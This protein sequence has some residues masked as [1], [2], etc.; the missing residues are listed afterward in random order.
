MRCLIFMG[1]AAVHTVDAYNRWAKGKGISKDV[2]VH[3]HVVQSGSDFDPSTIVILVFFDER[4]H[5]NWVGKAEKY[6]I[7]KALATM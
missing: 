2:I 5:E 3:S 4:L 1:M 7:E 6:P